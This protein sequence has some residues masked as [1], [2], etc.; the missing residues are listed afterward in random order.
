VATA[1]VERIFSALSIIKID[2]R[3][4]MGDEWL[5]DLICYNEKVIFRKIDNE[6]IKKRFQE[7]KKCHMLLPKKI[8]GTL[9]SLLIS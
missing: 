6:K 9:Y 4:K 1:S 8:S 3:N 2:L 5:N 7:M